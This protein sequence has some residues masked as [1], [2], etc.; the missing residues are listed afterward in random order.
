MSMEID[1]E[2]STVLRGSYTSETGDASYCGSS[3]LVTVHQ[4]PF[5]FKVFG[6][7]KSHSI[8]S[9]HPSSRERTPMTIVITTLSSQDYPYKSSLFV[10]CALSTSDLVDSDLHWLS[11]ERL[12]HM[13]VF[14]RLSL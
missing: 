8:R 2:I 13:L 10:E 1:T 7:E 14:W 12:S 6:H 9:N 5:C 11:V 4:D 3:Y